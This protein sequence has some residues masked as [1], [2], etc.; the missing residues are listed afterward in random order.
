[1]AYL[2]ATPV[3]RVKI[4]VTQASV[5]I[6][7]LLIIVVV[8]YVAGIVGAE[9]FLQDNNLNKE[10]FLKIN[11][12]GGLTFLVVSAYSFSFLVYVMMKEKHL[13]TQQV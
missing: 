13:A 12:V 9:W 4:A 5:L 3:S 11:I 2:L 10:L 7:G 8:T 1:M 6:L